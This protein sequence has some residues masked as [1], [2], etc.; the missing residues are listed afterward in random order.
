MCPF[1]LLTKYLMNFISHFVFASAKSPLTKRLHNVQHLH[2]K[3]QAV[4]KPT[5]SDSECLIRIHPTA[6]VVGLPRAKAKQFIA[7]NEPFTRGWYV[8]AGIV[9]DS[10]PLSEW[11]EIERKSQAL[12]KL[13]SYK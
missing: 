11:Q 5:I 10:E 6:A 4:L 12:A 9:Q 3:I 13:L 8:G 2:R 7:E 1:R